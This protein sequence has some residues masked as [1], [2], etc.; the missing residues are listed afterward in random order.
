M[1]VVVTTFIAP[2]WLKYLAPPLPPEKPQPIEGIEEL[3][4]GPKG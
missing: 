1:M 4:V 3:V 2:P